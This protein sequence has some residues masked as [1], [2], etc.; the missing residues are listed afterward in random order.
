MNELTLK[1]YRTILFDLDGTLTDPGEGILNAVQ[2]AIRQM[3]KDIPSKQQLRPFVGP[4]LAESFQA[5]C[6][7]DAEEAKAAIDH[8]RVYFLERGMFENELFPGIPELLHQLKGQGRRLIL[9]TSKPAVF[10]ERILQ[11][12]KL[13]SFFEHIG[14]S[15]LDGTRSDKTQLIAHLA[16][17]LDIDKAAA[18]MVGDRKHDIIGAANNGLASIGIGFG[19]G[20]KQELEDA[21]AT[22]YFATIQDLSAAFE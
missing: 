17:L 20:S 9:C 12:F 22:H 1:S 8:Y 4:P 19:Y 6:G 16:E 21:G 13:E 18:V 15:E 14:G 2:F 11:H 3:N 7:M 10:A 5:L